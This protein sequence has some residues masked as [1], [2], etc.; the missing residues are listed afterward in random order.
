MDKVL[1]VAKLV[2]RAVV[3][4]CVGLAAQRLAGEMFDKTFGS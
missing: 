1:F 3:C 2:T 4:L